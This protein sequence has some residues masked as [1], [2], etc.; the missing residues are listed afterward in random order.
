MLKQISAPA[1]LALLLAACS[2]TPPTGEKAPRML[3]PQSLESADS[4]AVQW[5][6]NR[7]SREPMK[8]G[9]WQVTD[10]RHGWTRSTRSA[11]SLPRIESP[12]HPAPAI[13]HSAIVF[14]KAKRKYS[15]AVQRGE[16]PTWEGRCGEL[17]LDQSVR[18]GRA[19][20]GVEVPTDIRQSLTCEL[21][22]GD[23]L[24]VLQ[25][26]GDVRP[27]L[28]HIDRLWDGQLSDGTTT[29][30]VQPAHK[31]ANVPF[32]FPVPVGY[33]FRGEEHD[34]GASQAIAPFG[35][36]FAENATDDERELMVVATA[37]LLL[38]S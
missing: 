9:E 16:G 24:W 14:D 30:E 37:A 35:M 10:F 11:E 4:V 36:R 8:I 18:I 12:A 13:A 29:I 38:H 27:R 2:T 7:V 6:T 22:S 32:T 28:G 25:L 17:Q 34:L 33:V 19:S 31:L 15:F 23:K 20:S 21:T 1:A 3:V 26:L 5:K